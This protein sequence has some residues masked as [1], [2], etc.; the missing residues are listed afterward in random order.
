MKYSILSI[1]VLGLP[2]ALFAQFPTPSHALNKYPH[3]PLGKS[4]PR[5]DLYTRPFS[6]NQNLKPLFEA[7]VQAESIGTKRVGIGLGLMF[8]L[9]QMQLTEYG[10]GATGQIRYRFGFQGKRK[11]ALLADV[12]VFPWRE[13]PSGGD[14]PFSWSSLRDSMDLRI[15]KPLSWHRGS[16]RSTAAVGLG[17]EYAPLSWLFLQGMAGVEMTLTQSE[18]SGRLKSELNQFHGFEQGVSFW[19]GRIGLRLG[20]LE[21]FFGIMASAKN[22]PFTHFPS[23]PLGGTRSLNWDTVFQSGLMFH[24]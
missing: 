17:I 9:T 6:P 18:N 3:T 23:N 11:F 5:G 1:I 7:H 2:L 19:S 24:L 14:R 15:G 8:S 20:K 4:Q 22:A 16:K 10:L 12:N 13:A 21:T